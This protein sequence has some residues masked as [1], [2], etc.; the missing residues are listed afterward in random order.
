VYPRFPLLSGKY[1]LSI[2]LLKNRIAE[3]VFY[4]HRASTFQMSFAGDDHGTVYLEH[5]WKYKLP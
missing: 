4:K 1:Y 5:G 2:G 3:P